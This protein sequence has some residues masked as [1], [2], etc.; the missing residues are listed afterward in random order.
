MTSKRA[1]ASLAGFLVALVV[2]LA[3]FTAR[4]QMNLYIS[5]VNDPIKPGQEFTVEV[6]ADLDIN[7][8]GKYEFPIYYDESLMVL[9]RAEGVPGSEFTMPV[10][11]DLPFYE[12]MTLRDE[13]NI[14]GCS[15]SGYTPLAYLTFEVLDTAAPGRT[16]Y[17]EFGNT[18][19]MKDCYGEDITGGLPPPS[20][21]E[22]GS[23]STA[24]LPAGA[25]ATQKY[26]DLDDDYA[27]S[28]NDAELL[29]KI[30]DNDIGAG[31]ENLLDKNARSCDLNGNAVSDKYDAGRMD[32][33]VRPSRLIHSGSDGVCHSEALG[34]DAQETP[35]G[36]GEPGAVVISPGFNAVLDTTPGGD[37]VISGHRILTGPDGLAGSTA[38]GDDEQEIPLGN[39]RPNGLCVLP[40]RNQVMDSTPISDDVSVEDLKSNDFIAAHP[41]TGAPAR[42][43]LI[44]PEQNPLYVDRDQPIPITVAVRDE[45][46][47]A[48]TGISPVF[49]L[50]SGQG[51]FQ[52]SQGGTTV[53]S[54][55]ESD[56]YADKAGAPKGYSTVVLYPVSG[57]NHIE[58]S[59][60]GDPAKGVPEP[61]PL[62]LTVEVLEQSQMVPDS[63]TINAES[64]SIMAGETAV[65]YLTVTAGGEPVHGLA[66]RIKLLSLRNAEKGEDMTRFGEDRPMAI[67][68]DRFEDGDITGWSYNAT[69][70]EFQVTTQSAGLF[71]DKALQV[72]ATG[73]ASPSIW[74]AVS[75]E[76][77][78]DIQFVFEYAFVGDCVEY[79]PRFIVEYSLDGS[80]W[81]RLRT[82][83]SY[84]DLAGGSGIW[85]GDRFNLKGVGAINQEQIYIRFT[86]DANGSGVL[87]TLYLDNVGVSGLNILNQEGFESYQDG[88]FPSG[89]LQPSNFISTG[90]DGILDTNA[91][92][93]DAVLFP[94]GYGEAY[95]TIIY[96]GLDGALDT[97]VLGD[98]TTGSTSTINSGPD[99]VA[100][101]LAEGDDFQEIPQ[102][103]GKPWTQG[104]FPGPDHIVDS[105]P[106]NDDFKVGESGPDPRIE[107]DSSIGSTTGPGVGNNGSDKFLFLGRSVAGNSVESYAVAMK[108]DLED[109][110]QVDLSFYS[111]TRSQADPASNGKRSQEFVV[112]VSDNGGESWSRVWDFKGVDESS[113]TKH[114]VLLYDDPR[115]NLVDDFLVRF[116]A[117]MDSTEN[118][119]TDPDG[120]YLDD[121]LVTGIEPS[122]DRF[123][124]VIDTND[125]QGTYKV[126]YS[127]YIPGSSVEISAAYWPYQINPATLELPVFADPTLVMEV[128]ERKA[129]PDSIQVLPQNFTLKACQSMNVTVVGRYTDT[130]AGQ[131]VDMTRFFKLLVNG[132][133]RQTAPGVITA[134]C[135][136]GNT[137]VPI[138][139][140]AK[141]LIPSLYDPGGGGGGEQTGDVSGSI[142]TPTYAKAPDAPVWLDLGGGEVLYSKTDSAG[143]HY[144]QAVPAGSGYSLSA[145]KEGY[146]KKT[147]NVSVSAGENTTV[148]FA[149][150]SGANFDGDSYPDSTDTDDDDDGLSD[151]SESLQGSDA[152]NPDTD[153]DGYTDDVD[154]FPGDS[155]EW[156]DTDG[157]GTGDNADTDDDGDGISDTEEES[158]GSDGYIT[159]PKDKDTDGGG[160]EDGDEVAA[161]RDPTDSSDDVTSSDS[162]GDGL[163]DSYETNTGVYVSTTDT[164][165]D[166]NSTDTDGDGL[167]DYAEVYTYGTDPNTND[168]DSDGVLDNV[169]T[170]STACT[171]AT[172]ADTDGD[173]LTDGTEDANGDGV[174]D[175][176]ETDPCDS[177]TDEDGMN[178]G[179]EVNNGLDPLT[180]DAS[181]DKDGDG[182]SNMAEC[183]RS[184]YA[185]DWDSDDDGIPDGFEALHSGDSVSLDPLDS[186]D[187][188]TTDFDSDLN[189]NVHEYWNGTDLWSADPQGH[190]GSGQ[191]GCAY[192]GEGDGDVVVASGDVT[193]LKSKIAE[194]PTDYSNVIP[195]NA[196][197]QDLDRDGVLA[198][199]DLTILKSM[200]SEIELNNIN[201]RAKELVVL[202]QPSGPVQVGDTCHVTLGVLSE[203]PDSDKYT[204][205]FAVVFLVGSS[206]TGTATLW[207][208]D[209]EYSG[210]R[211]DFSGPVAENAPARITLRIDSAGTIYMESFIPEC[212]SGTTAY[213]GRYCPEIVL[214][215]SVEITA[216]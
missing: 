153:G 216:E 215:P 188:G 206:S 118:D 10:T 179:Y 140:S 82:A 128:K 114:E 106:A 39:G 66:N 115:F 51:Y 119:G 181:G 155:T 102:G 9:K 6:S 95:S 133:A 175:A 134:D 189:P 31:D 138:N 22:A 101:S 80:N 97:S 132:P 154:A 198:S 63:M 197:T 7:T 112:E 5:S 87:Q 200:V 103:N 88:D 108:L 16:T 44:S 1:S 4:A 168:T 213:E 12:K 110:D 145:S 142:Y 15:T 124:S 149:L 62:S 196:D 28:E 32:A 105:V 152:Y 50:T 92:N 163:L 45:R 94:V 57:S 8:L 123:S 93:D 131:L 17:I 68:Q 156:L 183:T 121:I 75:T 26:M 162:D 107:V 67:F 127:S 151:S 130:P 167:G 42:L 169:E 20:Q 59:L 79:S 56:T 143:H 84:S 191:V 21:W 69:G 208:G 144:F 34:D 24:A 113:W 65:I 23:V 77:F 72:T 98:D 170:G 159:D 64:T 58:V 129:E 164:G 182:L 38:S 78:K 190:H 185:N 18:V 41:Q 146:T 177:D 27:P 30:V 173:G 33:L 202:S 161:G 117:S 70:G 141:P 96:P 47:A 147:A 11:R 209:G 29:H 49:R 157:D 180:D 91:L 176:S 48:K 14:Q 211:Y 13:H 195:D 126:P 81:R 192:W 104:I 43:E 214:S 116:R 148:S 85:M 25:T 186:S 2:L 207:G 52:G 204:A 19:V 111:R 172:V 76:D 174:V 109:M 201:S 160:E 90:D 139:I 193:V 199:G 184:T 125:G 60:P 71:G 166:P 212:Q 3:G 36:Q 74:R 135:F 35:V 187:G 89:S 158:V 40:G 210:E 73:T 194:T 136:E 150:Q 122:V 99:G 83:D 37:D 55:L 100:D 171:S 178:D 46:G 137:T 165:S 205:G 86:F 53:I 61:Q 54:Q 203:Y 120:V